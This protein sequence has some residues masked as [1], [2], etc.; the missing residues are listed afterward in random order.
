M[1]G[2]PKSRPS[3]T[4]RELEE[5]TGF[6]RR[7]IAYY[8]QE[9]LLPRVGRRGPRTQ[10]PKLTRDRLLFIRRI[11]EAEEA[12]EVPAVSLSEMRMVFDRVSPSLIARVADGRL[13]VTPELVEMAPS[14]FRPP[15]MRRMALEKRMRITEIG[16]D[17]SVRE[18]GLTHLEEDEG[19]ARAL[20]DMLVD[21]QDRVRQRRMNAPGSLDT[22]ARIEITPDIVVSVRGIT[23]EDKGLVERVRRVMSR[24]IGNRQT[25]G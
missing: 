10:Y 21:L 4:A 9:G 16:Y 18:P 7:T 17:L 2:K 8:I 13:A 14:A 25:P 6:D 22:W 1:T 19:S 23:D 24:V 12:G 5:E 3:Y 11:R 20:A 15:E